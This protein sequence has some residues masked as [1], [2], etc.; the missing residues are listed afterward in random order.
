MIPAGKITLRRK[1]GSQCG[2]AIVDRSDYYAISEYTWRLLGKCRH[3]YA[4][5]YKRING[6]FSAIL[7]HRQILDFPTSETI[8]H[9]NGDGLDNRRLN[10]RLATKAENCR[11]QLLWPS[12]VG[13]LKGATFVPAGL[14]FGKPWM[15]QI[16]YDGKN[17]NLGYYA[18]EHEAHAAYCLEAVKTWGNFANDGY[19]PIRI[20]NAV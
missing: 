2:V 16:G 6:K 10:L 11:N 20:N 4:A 19:G 12:K 1:D 3:Q 14:K 15:S 8:D 5:R 13:K 9:I 18:T 7:M 17:H